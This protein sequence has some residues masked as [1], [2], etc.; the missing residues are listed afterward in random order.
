MFKN[1]LHMFQVDISSFKTAQ[2]TNMDEMFYGCS[3]LRFINASDEYWSTESLEDSDNNMFYG[4][5]NL[6]QWSGDTSANS[7]SVGEY[8]KTGDLMPV[9]KS[10]APVVNELYAI[11]NLENK[12]CGGENQMVYS[13][14]HYKSLYGDDLASYSLKDNYDDNEFPITDVKIQVLSGGSEGEYVIKLYDG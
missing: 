8:L 7:A 4:C 6:E 3:A 13:A 5:T 14:D 10:S 9:L 11:G 12:V 1:C 2:V